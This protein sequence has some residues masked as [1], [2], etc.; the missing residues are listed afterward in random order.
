MRHLLFAALAL[1]LL[2]AAAPIKVDPAIAKAVADP[3]R[4]ADNRAR[5]RYRHPAETLSFFGVKPNQT[6]VEFIPSSG[7]YSEILAPMVKG[8]GKYVALVTSPKAADGAKAMLADT[9]R[10]GTVQ[11]ATLD[12]AAGTSTVPAGSADVVLTFRNVHNLIMSS[13]ATAA[14]AFRAFY[15]ALKPG[16]TLGV[17]DHRLPEARDAA[18]E[19]KS[20]YLKRST[21]VR[22]ATQAGFRLVG[23]SEVNANPKD[24]AD[25]PEGVWTLPPVYR[26]KDQDRA[27]YAAIGESDRMTLKFMKPKR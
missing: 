23:E 4:K 1:P 15:A 7:W 21:I 16:G 13:D 2:V 22:L 24:T 3:A 5:D 10:F 14:G 8:K 9:A 11:V 17:V 20:G 26:L 12:A 27:K 18:M 19:Q 25:H 6:V